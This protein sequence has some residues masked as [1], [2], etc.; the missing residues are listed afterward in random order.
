MA[1]KYHGC[2]F[3]G[4]VEFEVV[5]TPVVMGYCHCDD[6]TS[7]LGAPVSAFSLWPRENLRITKGEPNVGVFNKSE[8]AYRKFCT[9]C[10]GALM[11]DHPGMGLVDVYPA[12]MSDFSHEPTV[13]VHYEKKTISMQDGLPKFRDLPADFGGT[14]EM[15][16]D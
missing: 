16:P 14:G 1:Q 7:W 13:H 15:L 3:C 8:A 5:G 10:G 11:T 6:C 9:T 4:S 12:L 2:C